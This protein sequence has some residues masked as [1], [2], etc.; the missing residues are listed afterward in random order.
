LAV[1]ASTSSNVSVVHLSTNGLSCLPLQQLQ[2]PGVEPLSFT[3]LQYLYL[4]N[5][6][7][8]SLDPTIPVLRYIEDQRKTPHRQS[9]VSITDSFIF[10]A[11]R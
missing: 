2:C 11:L 3:E 4:L 1:A 8:W 5:M 6:Q 9:A 10:A 7:D